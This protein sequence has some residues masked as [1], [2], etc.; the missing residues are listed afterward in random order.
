MNAPKLA[1]KIASTGGARGP[2]RH[3]INAYFFL[4]P[5][6]A[7]ESIRLL[8]GEIVDYTE[9]GP[10]KTRKGKESNVLKTNTML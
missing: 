3:S 9:T 10:N 2:P 1:V 8:P 5:L 4:F 6:P 7:N